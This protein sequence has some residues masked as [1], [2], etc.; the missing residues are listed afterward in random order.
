ML[1]PI[2]PPVVPVAGVTWMTIAA[3]RYGNSSQGHC[4][5]ES[6]SFDKHRRDSVTDPR[7]T[8]AGQAMFRVQTCLLKKTPFKQRD[9]SFLKMARYASDIRI[10]EAPDFCRSQL[11]AKLVSFAS[12]MR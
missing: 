3:S 2:M 4:G 9:D 6:H 7:P 1:S 5:G 8:P 10:K 11:D 12:W